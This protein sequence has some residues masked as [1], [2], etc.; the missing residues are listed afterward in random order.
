MS[1][2]YRT[3]QIIP[4]GFGDKLRQPLTR[5]EKLMA[6]TNTFKVGDIVKLKSGGP[7]MTVRV[8]PESL[9]K[10]Y[11]CQWFAGKKLE[12]CSFPDESLEPV[13]DQEKK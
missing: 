7:E 9:K 2:I 4:Q 1:R 11:A 6:A 10:S 12:Q 5:N 3:V 13:K 8:V